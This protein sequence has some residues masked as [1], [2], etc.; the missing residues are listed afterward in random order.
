MKLL[1]TSSGI[2]NISIENTLKDL[3][4]KG[5]SESSI[6]YVPTA[7]NVGGGDKSWAIN[8]M[9][10]LVKLGFASVDIVD[11]SA[12][13]KDMWM[14]RLLDA[15]VIYFEGGDT[16]HLVRTINSS[17]F[18]GEVKEIFKDKIWVGASAGSMVTGPDLCL[19]LS[20]ELYK[21]DLEEKENLAGLNLVDF[22]I[23]P[24]F[25]SKWFPDVTEETVR[26]GV[27]D[28]KHKVYLLDDNSA[29]KVIDQN[30]EVVSEG[31]Y[32]VI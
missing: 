5:F 30:I 28:Y 13:S 23:I 12:L 1:L 25:G 31:K 7:M 11:I 2:T 10:K 22:Y 8:S 29:V 21:E 15:D 17:G 32:F 20:Q 26:E 9:R 27:K 19:K 18:A 24:H 16:F 3:L 14:R 4:G 6:A